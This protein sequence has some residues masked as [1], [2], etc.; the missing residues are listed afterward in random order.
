MKSV[1]V[2]ALVLLTLIFFSIS[3]QAAMPTITIHSPK[4]AVYNT[5]GILIDVQTSISANVTY[6]V[7]N[8]PNLTLF[9]DS[10]KANRSST[11][12]QSFVDG[13]NT[14]KV[15]ATDGN[16]T[17]VSTV[18]LTVDTE[19]PTLTIRTPDNGASFGKPNVFFEFVPKDN[20][21][22]SLACAL[23]INNKVEGTI[24]VPSDFRGSFDKLLG[25][26]NYTWKVSCQDTANNTISTTRTLTV[27]PNCGVFVRNLTINNN[28]IV[29]FLIENTGTINQIVDYTLKVNLQT[30]VINYTKIN[31][32][33]SVPVQT[34]YNFPL[35]VHQVEAEAKTDCGATSLEKLG[36]AKS[37]GE[38]TSC[39]LPTG[40]HN[41]ISC[42]TNK[43]TLIQC[44]NGLWNVYTKDPTG[45]CAS[46]GHC[47]DGT[48]NCGET[49]T[50]CPQDFGLSVSCDCTNRTLTLGLTPKTG[51][52]FYNY[53]KS[54]CNLTCFSDSDCQEGAQ[55]VDYGCS[56]RSG[57]CLV[58]VK[59]F[60][61]TKQLSVSSEGYAI[62]TIKNTGVLNGSVNVKFFV[63]NLERG[64]VR[65]P[66]MIPGKENSTSFYFK[67]NQPGSKTL[68]LEA[69][70][71]CGAFDRETANIT[72]YTA[73]TVGPGQSQSV[74][75]ATF[76]SS[77]NA[78]V[79]TTVGQGK[80]LKLGLLSS[81]PQVIRISVTGIPEEWLDYPKIIGVENDRSVRIFV[82]PKTPGDYNFTVFVEGKEKNFTFASTL[83]V[84]DKVPVKKLE[85]TNIMLIIVVL[86]AIFCVV[87][88]LGSR[89]L[90]KEGF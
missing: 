28:N 84:L 68:K 74:T 72:V 76:S 11:F 60:D 35:G 83:K 65:L 32:T 78:T 29:S 41:Q 88:Y 53:C 55:C 7:N 14:L 79:N 44:Q 85:T 13:S 46:C 47:G 54:S 71:S 33:K 2:F 12:Y 89:V 26:G 57:S 69:T 87:V 62:A 61:Y 17:A 6:T 90:H 50:S 9:T 25:V 70:S 56:Q 19:I 80:E 43:R 15:F 23:T 30:A 39:I 1:A 48:V 73:N 20:L 59:N 42:D 58:S 36:Y 21:A 8:G 82:D 63:D 34:V 86:I 3:A 81:Q 66:T 49:Q 51:Q 52:E 16:D 31:I 18:S 40:N 37:P 27:Q 22:A 75:E 77:E 5:T 64:N 4:A 10:N 45:Y 67:F 24:D 38:N